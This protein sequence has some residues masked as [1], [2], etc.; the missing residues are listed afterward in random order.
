MKRKGITKET[1]DEIVKKYNG[2]VT[3]SKLAKDYSLSNATIYYY[4]GKKKQY[5][6]KLI[7]IIKKVKSIS[8]TNE[9]QINGINVT[10]NDDVL[11]KVIKAL[12]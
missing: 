4:L 10:C 2:G 12:I 11:I 7:N 6:P 8:N 3:V 5:H 9:L 1:R